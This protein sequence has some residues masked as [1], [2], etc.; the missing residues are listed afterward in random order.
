MLAV[1]AAQ[2]CGQRVAAHARERLDRMHRAVGLAEEGELPELFGAHPGAGCSGVY[3]GGSRSCVRPAIDLRAG[4]PSAR[5][6]EAAFAWSNQFLGGRNLLIAVGH[7]TN[8]AR[9]APV[10]SNPVLFDGARQVC[11]RRRAR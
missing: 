4:M 11:G 1:V 5:L 6:D 3:I 9:G 2:A 8:V 7:I 10:G